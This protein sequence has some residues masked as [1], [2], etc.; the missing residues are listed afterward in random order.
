M[1][2]Q[3]N[4]DNLFRSYSKTHAGYLDSNNQIKLE[5]FLKYAENNYLKHIRLYGK[6]S[7][8]ILEI[9]CNKGYLL[10]ALESHGYK[11][12]YGIDLS[13]EDVETAKKLAPPAS[14][15]YA[16]AFDYLD[17]NVEKFDVIILKAV[18]EHIP[19]D[20]VLPLLEKI[21][22]SL[23]PGGSVIIDVPNMDWIFAQ[24]ERYMDFTHEVGFTKESLS[25]VMRNV[26]SS[27]SVFK[28]IPVKEQGFRAQAWASIRPL[29]IIVLNKLFEVIGEGASE[30]WWYNRSIIGVGMK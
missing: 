19:K 2:V 27:V 29:L 1:L 3:W 11:N 9:G 15:T 7:V 12:L 26:F 14:I 10:A 25:Q 20:K 23:R 24:H 16:D 4:R 6:D 8:H 17:S 5:W 13:P 21:K 30:V 18:L 22:D 28:G